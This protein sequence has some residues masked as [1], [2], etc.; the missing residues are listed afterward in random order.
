MA[1]QPRWLHDLQRTAPKPHPVVAHDGAQM[2]DRQRCGL[3][4]WTDCSDPLAWATQWSCCAHSRGRTQQPT[5]ARG[6]L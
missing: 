6:P 1:H 3:I 2:Q 4:V 5:H